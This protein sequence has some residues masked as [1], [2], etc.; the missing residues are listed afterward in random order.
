MP[1]EEKIDNKIGKSG[2]GEQVSDP[3]REKWEG[4][5]NKESKNKSNGLQISLQHKMMLNCLLKKVKSL[6]LI[7]QIL[8]CLLISS[9]MVCVRY[10]AYPITLLGE[11]GYYRTPNVRLLRNRT[12]NIGFSKIGLETLVISCNDILCLFNLFSYLNI[13]IC[14]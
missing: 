10:V 7:Y 11:I 2:Q 4:G 8:F 1:S 14:S 13:C 9:R 5:A 6:P 12:P 3:A